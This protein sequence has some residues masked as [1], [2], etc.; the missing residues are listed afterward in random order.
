MPFHSFSFLLGFLP[1][2]Y[3]L[4]LFA[5]WLGGW[6]LAI[7]F[8]GLASLTYYA[9]F[10]LEPLLIL[11]VSVLANYYIGEA[12]K[13]TLHKKRIAGTFLVLGVLG[14]LIALGYFKYT[15]FLIDI[16]NQLSGNEFSHLQLLLPI[17]I[18]FFS[19]IQ[20]G[21]LIEA[22]NGQ[23]EH[24]PLSRYL[25]FATFFPCIAAGPLV[26]QREMFG[27]MKNRT[28]RAFDLNRLATG[29][30]L[31]GMGLFK[32]CVLADSIA[33]FSN[34]VFEGV[35]AG[36]ALSQETAWAGAL[37]Y[38]LQL[39]FD[40]S[41]YSDMAI[42]LGLI[43]GLK[44]PLNFNSPFKA[45]NIS[46]FWRRWH[47]TMTR[48]FTNFVYTPMAMNGMRKAFAKSASPMSRYMKTAALPAIVTFLVAG[49][50]HGDG[51][52]FVVYGLIH[53][54]AIAAYL[55]WRE[56][57]LPAMPK[58]FAWALTMSVVV[59]GLVVFR[60]D[61]IETAITILGNMWTPI[62]MSPAHSAAM[63]VLDLKTAFS[64][65]TLLGAIVLLLPNTQQ[66]L[67]KH[68]VSIDPMPPETKHE[69]GLL[70][71]HPNAGQSVSIGMLC[72]IAISSL[73]AS[74]TFLYY[75]F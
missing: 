45:T 8:L 71:W 51:W 24:Q 9:Q 14:N 27:Q 59:N 6:K 53:G 31:F 48:F 43:F 63:V 73:G 68:W 29:L 62:F 16:T 42:A 5:Y 39:Y 3:I 13:S 36:L 19:F 4:F 38:T 70:V 60:A 55:G 56:L 34:T 49:I 54:F 67:H 17:G 74:S 57:K 20:I 46:D 64:Y 21:Y 30:T 11:G 2:C 7:Q 69:A 26:L 75:Q 18:S 1:A 25:V 61:T 37:S 28:D 52:T 10:D 40:F 22:Y 41:G 35:N 23:V 50:W 33:P 66:I 58:P 72:C 44:L 15:N 47:M 65:I 12:I 32:K